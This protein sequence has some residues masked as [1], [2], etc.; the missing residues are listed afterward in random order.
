MVKKICIQYRF[1]FNN[2]A[3]HASFI[4]SSHSGLHDFFIILLLN[5]Y[6]GDDDDHDDDGKSAA[7]ALLHK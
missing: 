3:T 2:R 4:M 1:S 6:K 7:V 5:E